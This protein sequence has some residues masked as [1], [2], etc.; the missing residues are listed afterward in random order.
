M[1]H[2]RD[3]HA[4]A[5]HARRLADITVQRNIEEIL[6]CVAAEF[7]RLADDGATGKVD[8]H[9]REILERR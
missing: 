1:D 6:R 5:D 3:Y 7:D 9:D 8:F 2:S 4:Q